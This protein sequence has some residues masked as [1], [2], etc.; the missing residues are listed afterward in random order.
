MRV[1][2]VCTEVRDT[3]A[4]VEHAMPRNPANPYAGIGPK[5]TQSMLTAALLFALKDVLYDMTVKARRNLTN[6][7]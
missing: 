5:V 7:A 1:L 4:L 2:A 3:H 6:K